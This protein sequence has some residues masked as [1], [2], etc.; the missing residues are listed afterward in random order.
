MSYD[1]T[2]IFQVKDLPKDLPQ[3]FPP[4]IP[5]LDTKILNVPNL[6]VDCKKVK[7]V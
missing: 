5:D 1:K 3:E 2:K 6:D 4:V 7:I